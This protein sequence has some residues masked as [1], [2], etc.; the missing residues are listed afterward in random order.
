[1]TFAFTMHADLESLFNVASSR[2]T[3]KLLND[4]DLVGNSDIKMRWYAP[5]SALGRFWRKIFAMSAGRTVALTRFAWSRSEVGAAQDLRTPSLYFRDEARLTFGGGP[6]FLETN[7]IPGQ[8]QT[9][10]TVIDEGAG[11]QFN[12]VISYTLTHTL[13]GYPFL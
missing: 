12:A 6:T 10:N 13:R 11:Q 3:F 8:P 4:R 2:L 7:L 5:D 9:L 1:M